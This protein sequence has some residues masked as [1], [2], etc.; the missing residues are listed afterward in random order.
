M[1]DRPLAIGNDDRTEYEY[2]YDFLAV[3]TA[4]T[5]AVPA[6]RTWT[7]LDAWVVWYCAWLA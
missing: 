6:A 2:E 7:P 4:A 3:V 5:V 1:P